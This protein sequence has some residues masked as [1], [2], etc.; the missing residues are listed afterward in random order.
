MRGAWGCMIEWTNAA[1][2]TK[3]VLMICAKC[4]REYPSQYYFKTDDVCIEITRGHDDQVIA[5]SV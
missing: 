4:K 2:P 1:E 3:G 5:A